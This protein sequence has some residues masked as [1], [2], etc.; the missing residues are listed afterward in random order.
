MVQDICLPLRSHHDTSASLQVQKELESIQKDQWRAPASLVMSDSVTEEEVRERRSRIKKVPC[1]YFLCVC[2]DAWVVFAYVPRRDT[3]ETG[4][5]RH[6]ACAFVLFLCM[7]AYVCMRVCS[8]R[9]KVRLSIG[10][11]YMHVRI[12]TLP[13]TREYGLR[14]HSQF[15]TPHM[16]ESATYRS[17]IWMKPPG[18]S[19]KSRA[20]QV[21]TAASA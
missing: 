21:S 19:N 6:R 2:V 1:V 18:P 14:Q 12:A 16:H 13:D 8:T 3:T 15:E 11:V 9:L 5:V 10:L 4:R 20:R 17:K 7:Y